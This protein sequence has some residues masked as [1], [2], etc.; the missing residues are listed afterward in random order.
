MRVFIAEAIEVEVEVQNLKGEKRVKTKAAPRSGFYN[1][2]DECG[3]RLIG[4]GLAYETD[5]VGSIVA[6]VG[7]QRVVLDY[8]AGDRPVA[9]THTSTPAAEPESEPEPPMAPEPEAEETIDD[10][11]YPLGGDPEE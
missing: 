11:P 2:T 10:D 4:E 6:Y 7:D 8:D 3:D 1:V 5:G 9:D